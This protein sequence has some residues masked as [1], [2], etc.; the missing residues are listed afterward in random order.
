VKVL[1]LQLG[2]PVSLDDVGYG[3]V[4]PAGADATLEYPETIGA[5]VTA[6][7]QLANY[8]LRQDDSGKRLHVV[9]EAWDGLL[10]K[11]MF[12]SD[13]EPS[14]PV[15]PRPIHEM[16]VHAVR[17]A[18]EMFGNFDYRYGGGRPKPLVARYLETDVLPLI[19]YVSPHTALGQEYFREVA[20]LTRLAGWTAYD[21]GHH[22]LAQ[23]YLYQAFRLARAGGDK[24]LCGRILAG[25]SHQANFLGHYERAVHLARAAAQGAQSQATPTTMALFHAMEAR[26]LASQ[27]N[28]GETATALTTAE[29]WMARSQPENDPSWI[30]Y[31]DRAELHAEFAHCFR[32]LG[33]SDLAAHHAQASINESENMYVRSLSFCRTV[34]ATAHLQANELD[35]ALTVARGVVDTAAELKSF[36]VLSYVEDFQNRLAVKIN[37]SS[38]REFSEYAAGKL[39]SKGLPV[40]GTLVFA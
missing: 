5:A 6:L 29:A 30:K 27:G 18:T 13:S 19:P 16:D 11:W 12:G 24:A 1:G 37:E 7:T 8:E 4:A 25:M 33:D 32:D 2:R 39:P 26:A 31:F 35:E 36:R 14:Q 10:V 28:S 23:R 9:P 17:D 3:D 20:A 21:I 34:L 15:E 38:V 40:S 22:A